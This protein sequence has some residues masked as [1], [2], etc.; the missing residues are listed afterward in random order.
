M[1]NPKTNHQVMLAW[2]QDALGCCMIETL[3]LPILHNLSRDKANTSFQPWNKLM[4]KTSPKVQVAWRRWRKYEKYSQIQGIVLGFDDFPLSSP[5]FTWKNG[6][7]PS[8]WAGQV[9]VAELGPAETSLKEKEEV[10][11]W[12]TRQFLKFLLGFSCF[13]APSSFPFGSHQQIPCQRSSLI[14]DTHPILFKTFITTLLFGQKVVVRWGKDRNP[15]QLW[16]V[17]NWQK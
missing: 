7:F 5:L 1:I 8:I 6:D 3:R 16:E 4:F 13:F 10:P 17:S 15:V 14:G 11:G 2:K 12:L 9:E